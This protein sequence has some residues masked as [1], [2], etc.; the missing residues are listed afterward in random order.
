MAK[1]KFYATLKFYA[2][3]DGEYDY[4]LVACGHNSCSV[5]SVLGLFMLLQAIAH[6]A[7]LVWCFRKASIPAAA[8]AAQSHV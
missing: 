1:F 7:A 8:G 6:V 5:P 3:T 4:Y 2:G